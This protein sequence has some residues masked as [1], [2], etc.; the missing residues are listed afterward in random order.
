[1]TRWAS[2]LLIALL[3]LRLSP[4]AVG[5]RGTVALTITVERSDLNRWLTVDVD[6]GVSYTRHSLI[7]LDGMT[8]PRIL[9]ERRYADLPGGE[10]VVTLILYGSGDKVLARTTDRFTVLDPYALDTTSP[11]VLE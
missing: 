4:H 1:M 5:F 9:P 11:P 2:W 3:S 10:Y 7:Q 6:N 8:A